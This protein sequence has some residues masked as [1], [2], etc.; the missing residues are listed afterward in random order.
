M[1]FK[2]WKWDLEADVVAVGS[3]LGGLAAAIVA[4]DAGKKAVVLEKAAKLGGVCAYSGGEVFVPA[5]HLMGAAGIAD[6]VEE[7]RKYLAFLA[8]GY[9]EPEL[10]ESLLAT[11]PTCVRWF[12][13]HAGVRWKIIKGFADYHYPKAPGTVAQ[14]RYLEV[15]LFDGKTLGDW[16]KKTYLSPHM[17]NGITHDELL[18][19]GGFPHIMKWDFAL[20]GKR[21]SKDMR[22]LGPAMMASFV[23]AA[24]I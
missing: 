24:L 21:M 15:E 19:W 7:G 10:Q 23:K 1:A 11:G 14:G 3:G 5:N 6:S 17:P 16:Q 20:M 12:E 2:L 22:S 4:H 18:G 8:A 13:E 9:A